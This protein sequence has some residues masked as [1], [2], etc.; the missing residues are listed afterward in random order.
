MS[1]GRLV[2]LS[3]ETELLCKSSNSCLLDYTERLVLNF[4]P[5]PVGKVEHNSKNNVISLV[6]KIAQTVVPCRSRASGL[7]A[8]RLKRACRSK[9]KDTGMSWRSGGPMKSTDD[10][11]MC[12]SDLCLGGWR[13]ALHGNL[14]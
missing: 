2:H 4:C 8:G 7:W 14:R 3:R 11:S 6:C 12:A 5:R 9:W 13:R 1:I 10:G